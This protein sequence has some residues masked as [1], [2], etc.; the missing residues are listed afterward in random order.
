[1]LNLVLDTVSVLANTGSATFNLSY[2]GAGPTKGNMGVCFCFTGNGEIP[3]SITDNWG[4]SWCQLPGATGNLG[5]VCAFVCM[6]LHGGPTTVTGTFGASPIGGTPSMSLAEFTYTGT[7][8][9][10]SLQAPRYDLASLT[11]EFPFGQWAAGAPT[12]YDCAFFA[13]LYDKSG[14]SH[15]WGAS[16]GFLYGYTLE[17]TAGNSSATVWATE[18]MATPPAIT[19]I[20]GGAGS[21]S[22]LPIVAF[23]VF[24]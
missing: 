17:A 15:S 4:D 5:Q 1:M 16:T 12:T 14:N 9:I 13:G 24:D 22:P 3:P 21:T 6:Y 18:G 8:V 2:D 20:P 19:F 7:P 23:M 11:V 10:V